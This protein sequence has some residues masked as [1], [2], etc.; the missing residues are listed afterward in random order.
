MPQTDHGERLS[1]DFLGFVN[2]PDEERWSFLRPEVAWALSE[3]QWLE[4]GW[5]LAASGQVRGQTRVVSTAGGVWRIACDS[6]DSVA[7]LIPCGNIIKK[8]HKLHEIRPLPEI[9]ELSPVPP[10]AFGRPMA[11]LRSIP[12]KNMPEPLWHKFAWRMAVDA[13]TAETTEVFAIQNGTWHIRCHSQ[14]AWEFLQFPQAVLGMLSWFSRMRPLPE[15]RSIAPVMGTI[16]A[17]PEKIAVSMQ[18]QDDPDIP[19]TI[20]DP[21]MRRILAHLRPRNRSD[22]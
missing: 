11:M 19:Q 20:S 4:M 10:N 7:S 8:L 17:N 1:I 18:P 22:V 9:R 13:E 21:R 2:M 3:A 16:S 15:A 14:H 12:W 5:S 6:M